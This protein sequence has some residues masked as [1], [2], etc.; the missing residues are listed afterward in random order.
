M[1]PNIVEVEHLH[2]NKLRLSP[3]ELA[4][5]NR[6]LTTGWVLLDTLVIPDTSKQYPHLTTILGKPRTGKLNENDLHKG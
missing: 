5:I 6:A 2:S 3:S 1:Y 4:A